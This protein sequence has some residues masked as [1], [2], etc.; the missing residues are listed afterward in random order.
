M[1]A[2]N[3]VAL[4]AYCRLNS[5]YIDLHLIHSPHGGKLVQTYD[6]LLDLKKEG[7]IRYVFTVEN[8]VNS[9]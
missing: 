6:A 1:I 4:C 3:F 8:I 5:E 9:S 7:L 2:T